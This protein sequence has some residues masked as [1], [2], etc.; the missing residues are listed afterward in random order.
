MVDIKDISG[1]TRFSTPI[2]A[3]AKGRFTLMKED[4]IIL[5]FSVPDP[6]YFKLGDYVDLSGVLDES[7]GG[8]LSKVYEIVD[9]QKPAFNASTGGYDYQL[10]MDAYYWKW[11][12]KIFKYTPEHAGHEASWS[13]TA[14][15][16]VQ[17]GVFLRNLK[18]LGYT[19]KGKEF[20]FR[21]DS[22][23]ENKAVAMRYDNMNLLDALFSMAD[24]EKW[25]CDCW[26]T[27]NI[28]HFGRNEYGDS[29]RIELGV[30]ASAMTRS[31]S[32]GTYA[33]RIYAFGSTRNIPADYRP[34]DEQTVV[35][36]VVQRRLMLPADTPYIDVPT[37]PK[38]KR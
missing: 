34:V 10:R 28:I 7:L 32:K 1:K 29:V 11:K 37:C 18:A 8:L 36:G 33:T 24:K 13:L 5:P 19:Y 21:I 30:E 35:N 4:Y 12:N 14:P 16:D 26:I 20:E 27:D 31:D 2:N 9:L 23:V 15:L 6:V 3:G 22:T 17:L 38:R 25:D